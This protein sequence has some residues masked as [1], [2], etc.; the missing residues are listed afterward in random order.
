MKDEQI[1]TT[2]PLDVDVSNLDTSFPLVK[3]G[4][5]AEVKLTKVT[6]LNNAANTL[7][8]E[9]ESLAELPGQEEGKTFPAGHKF[10][11]NI[12]TEPT[13][14]SNWDII[15][16]GFAEFVQ[17]TGQSVTIRQA[18][19]NSGQFQGITGTIRVGLRP[20]GTGKD[21]VYRKAQNQVAEWIKKQSSTN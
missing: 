16:R 8:I 17:F 3:S 5:L 18:R 12:N 21:G 20:A 2:N 15:K 19:E 4:A 14:E 13:G 7:S 9:I 6:L 1:D 11:G 10:Y